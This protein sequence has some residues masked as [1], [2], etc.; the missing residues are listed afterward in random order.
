MDLATL[1]TAREYD[2]EYDWTLTELAARHD[3]LDAPVVD[4]VRERKTPE[5]LGEKEAALIEFGRELLGKHN[6][7]AETYARA[8]KV[9]GETDL[10]DFV[11]LIAQRSRDD[12]LLIGFDQH[13]PAGQKPLLA[14]R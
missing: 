11:T 12:V 10:V 8:L 13:L 2:E 3:G 1:V 6:V 5:G 14:D 9:F 7:S 4:V